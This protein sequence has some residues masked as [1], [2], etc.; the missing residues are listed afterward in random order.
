[1]LT[2]EREVTRKMYQTVQ[3]VRIFY[4]CLTIALL[5]YFAEN[6]RIENFKFPFCLRII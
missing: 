5:K 4:F 1:M 2:L 3:T 6:R